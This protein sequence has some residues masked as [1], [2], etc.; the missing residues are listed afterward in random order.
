[1]AEDYPNRFTLLA[2]EYVLGLMPERTRRRFERRRDRD[3]SLCVEVDDWERRLAP[4]IESLPP[5]EP[6][7]HLER[8]ILSRISTVESGKADPRRFWRGFAAGAAIAAMLAVLGFG[9][10]ELALPPSPR[11]RTIAVL[12]SATAEPA[13]V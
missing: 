6:P 1:M 10:R 13:L 9:A 7:P 12:L 4:L 11:D 3:A 2:A 8:A 5:I